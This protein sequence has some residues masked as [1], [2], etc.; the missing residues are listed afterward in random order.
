MSESNRITRK[1]ERLLF[2]GVPDK[3]E[4]NYERE[5]HAQVDD[6]LS[7]KSQLRNC[8][9]DIETDNLIKIA[10]ISYFIDSEKTI[11]ECLL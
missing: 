7:G 8:N 3:P 4:S 1:F 5:F 2:R 10:N 6:R 11:V 9:F